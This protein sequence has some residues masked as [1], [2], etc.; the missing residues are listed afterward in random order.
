[1]GGNG[2][3][4]SGCDTTRLSGGLTLLQD[5]CDSCCVCFKFYG[6]SA[7]ILIHS[8]QMAVKLKREEGREEGEET[9]GRGEE[10][11]KET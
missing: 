1:M 10:R 4:D 9:E 11:R 5:L 2:G 3:E 6:E 8:A 7:Q